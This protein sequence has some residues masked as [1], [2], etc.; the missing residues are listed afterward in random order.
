MREVFPA[1]GFRSRGGGISR[2]LGALLLVLA[3]P[4]LGATDAEEGV[5]LKL[6]TLPPIS[7]TDPLNASKARVYEAFRQAH[8][9]IRLRAVNQ[10]QV[11]GAASEGREYL[12]IAGGMAPDIFELYGRKVGD[13]VE[14][15]FILPLDPILRADPEYRERPF[16]GIWA[17]HRIW[18]AAIL[19]DRSGKLRLWGIPVWQYVMAIYYRVDLLAA[20]G[21]VRPPRNW[22]ELYRWARACTRDPFREP[23]AS[24]DEL[25][26]FGLQLP[27]PQRGG[28]WHLL[29]Y[30]WSAGAEVLKPFVRT[31]PRGEF[32]PW[33]RGPLPFKEFH[34]QISDPEAWHARLRRWEEAKRALAASGREVASGHPLAWRLMIDS[35]AGRAAL[36]FQK[37]LTFSEWIR[38]A[39]RDDPRHAVEGSFLEFD[40]TR[41]MREMGEARCPV[42]GERVDLT[43]ETGRRRV[44]RGVVRRADQREEVGRD[45]FAMSLA[46]VQEIPRFPDLAQVRIAPFPARFGGPPVSF[47]AGGYYAINSSLA[48]DP[49]RLQ[50]AW[51]FIK[52]L[53]DERALKIRTDTFVAMGLGA[54][55]RP[56]LLERFGH[57]E[58]LDRQSPALRESL[59]QITANTEVEPYARGFYHINNERF[60]VLL[61][62]V[63][64]APDSDVPSILHRITEECNTRILGEPSL[65]KLRQKER[66]GWGVLAG[67]AIALL[68]ASRKIVRLLLARQNDADAEGLGIGENRRRRTFRAWVFLFPAVVSILLWNY[69]PLARGTLMAFQNVR[70]LGGSEW[71]GLRHFVEVLTEPKFWQFLLQTAWYVTLSV[72]LGFAAPLLLA[73]LLSEVPQGKIFF[74]TIYYLPHLTTGLV[75]LFLWKQLMY[76]PAPEGLL[77]RWLALFGIDPQ[78]WLLDP[79]LAMFCVVLPGIWAGAGAG[80]LIYLAAM[81]GIPEEQYEAADLDGAGPLGKFRH[82]M[83]PNLKA[84][85]IINLVGAVVGAFHASQNI[86]VMTAGGPQEKTMTLGLDIWFK[87][88]LYLNFGYATAEAWVLGALLIGFTLTQLRILNRIRFHKAAD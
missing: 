24:P 68:F 23:G 15:G 9:D 78:R 87:S 81:K 37:R 3:I 12:A 21:L 53:T 46:Q 39:C 73:V 74:R 75:V 54:W 30:F 66:I 5:E 45:Q 11:E 83:L 7:T 26:T 79:S 63:L 34:I 14:Q 10:L 1:G 72:G 31:L 2:L 27:L 62:H 60:G 42:C 67:I 49:R 16:S 57:R 80:C 20:R 43:T 19:P 59:L 29:Q 86:F 56:D 77:N 36:E 4:S 85:L 50:A 65:K 32:V 76:N 61:E 64:A 28:G 84:L 13:Y 71:V 40:L 69:Y 52:F 58:I 18:E 17:P 8:P 25:R 22:E 38:C 48:C 70:L 51:K 41:E 55:V 44:Y 82:V 47:T 88:F 35:E 6:W 33:D